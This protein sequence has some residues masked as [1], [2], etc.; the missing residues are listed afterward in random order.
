ME[1]QA[2]R[3]PQEVT[4]FWPGKTIIGYVDGTVKPL[5]PGKQPD[6]LTLY[7]SGK[8]KAHGFVHWY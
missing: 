5:P 7:Y 4:A 6:L 2:E 8:K 3:L 1:A